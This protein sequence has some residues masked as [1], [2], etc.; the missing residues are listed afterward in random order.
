MTDARAEVLQEVREAAGPSTVVQGNLKQIDLEVSAQ[1]A[2][3]VA[4][5]PEGVHA[6][7]ERGMRSAGI[8]LHVDL[9][10]DPQPALYH[11]RDNTLDEISRVTA[12]FSVTVMRTKG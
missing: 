5:N 8:R 6:D 4:D 2:T 10:Q 12:A 7:D 11:R 9:A 3:P 1:R